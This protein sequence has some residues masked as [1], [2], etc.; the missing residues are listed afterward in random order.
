MTQHVGLLTC[1]ALIQTQLEYAPFIQSPHQV[2]KADKFEPVQNH[3]TRFLHSSYLYKVS[4]LAFAQSTAV[5]QWLRHCAAEPEDAGFIPGRSDHFSGR[6][7]I[8]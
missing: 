6:G 1:K 5:S 2:H 4:V 3:A 8:R 7:E